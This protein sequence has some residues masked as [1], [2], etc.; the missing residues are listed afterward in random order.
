MAASEDL[1][2][3]D[4]IESQKENIQSL[5]G[6]RSARKLA[7]LYSPQA[8][9]VQGDKLAPILTPTPNPGDTKTLHDTIRADFEAEVAVAAESD[10][11]LDVYDR[12]VRWTLD[13]YPSAQATP[14]SQ[15]HVLLERATKAFVGTAQYRNDP[16]Y[17]RLWLHYIHFFSDA[18]RETYLYLSRHGIGENLALFYEE[19]AGWLEGAT[20][21]AQADEVFRLGIER[22]ARPQ[23]RLMRKY[24]EFEQRRET[25]APESLDPDAPSSPAL[26]TVRPALAAKV[27]PFASAAAASSDPQEAIRQQEQQRQR[28][29]SGQA[30]RSA[31]SK[32]AIFSDAGASAGGPAL[33]AAGTTT[34][35]WESIGSLTERKKENTVAAKPWAGEKLSAGGK[36]PKT[37]M[38]V[39]KDAVQVNPASGKKERVFVD[40]R[41]VYPTPEEPGTELSF[42]EIW[43]ANRGLLHCEWDTPAKVE[44]DLLF[45][46]VPSHKI[47]VL[48][49]DVAS[50]LV[51]HHD[52]VMLDEN[53]AM[54]K[55]NGQE[56]RSRKKKF[57]EANVTQIIKAKLDSPSKPKMK[58]KSSSTSEPTM[59]MHTRA[60]TDDIYEIFNQPK[61]QGIEEEED[62]EP[63][64]DDYET[65]GDYTSGAESTGTA[66]HGSTSDAGDEEEEEEE[67]DGT[68]AD[69]D[70]IDGD[71]AGN[72]SGWSDFAA[73]K[74]VTNLQ[75]DHSTGPNQSTTTTGDT[76]D[77]GNSSDRDEADEVFSPLP[78]RS[79][80]HPAGVDIDGDANESK[81][82]SLPSSPLRPTDEEDEQQQA[83]PRT[84]TVFIP[85]PPEDYVAPTRPYR[86]PAEVANNRLPFMT[87]ITE[88]TESSLEFDSEDNKRALHA[89]TPSKAVGNRSFSLTSTNE[90]DEDEDE[91]EEVED[92][93][94]DVMVDEE[95]EEERTRSG[96]MT[97]PMSSPLIDIVND[98]ELPEPAPLKLSIFKDPVVP[99]TADSAPSSRAPVP[100]KGPIITETQCNPIDESI[101]A[102]ILAKM[103]P[104][105]SSYTGF[106]D[107]REEKCDKGAEIRRYAKAVSGKSKANGNGGSGNGGG[108]SDR[109][110]GAGVPVMIQ[111]ADCPSRYTVRR[112]IGAGAFAP[113]YL[114]ENM[115]PDGENSTGAVDDEQQAVA[116]MGRGAFA[117]T[118]ARRYALEALKMENPPTTWEFHMMRLAHTRLGP[119][120]RA[121]A[122]LAPALE[123][124]LY[125]D[126]TFLFLPYYPHGTLLDVVNLFRSEPSGV[127]DETLAMFFAIELFRTVESLHGKNIL[128]GDIKADNCLL[129]L[130]DPLSTASSLSSSTSSS[131]S[132]N[133]DG[134]EQ[135]SS[136]W[137][138]DGTGGWAARGMTLIDFGRAID[139]RA[140]PAD[141]KFVADWKTTAQDC[142]EMREGRPWTWQIDYHGLAGA[143]HCLLFGKYMETVRCD[144][145]MGAAFGG[146][147]AGAGGIGAALERGPIKRYRIRETLKR[148]WQTDIWSEAFELLLNP[149]G[150][151]SAEDGG[152][153]PALRSMRQ[154]RERME[155]WLAANCERG[156]GLKSLMIKIEHYARTRK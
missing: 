79:F 102:E 92:D 63:S 9:G 30:A 148:Y 149:A 6:G 111:F 96:I 88:R 39:F 48:A 86:D 49:D 142:A 73:Q 41:A 156:V 77:V 2:N 1:I 110:S 89:K 99:P 80:S 103:Q 32:M 64:D 113:V 53:G 20:R 155:T 69:A 97:E 55:N 71:E 147:T 131:N 87:P 40:L 85:I 46:P 14:Q 84:R 25:Q 22:N 43:A 34:K 154:I 17:L 106:Y 136:Q 60:A 36:K 31:K 143:L 126:E 117:S 75:E 128:H 4:V 12:Y 15:L 70:A 65:D 127:M 33:P 19:Y 18:P 140:F 13:A 138:A 82:P 118:H 83:P 62:N 35:G 3:F 28:Q 50:K 150:F 52:V 37:K 57:V 44:Q 66:R 58:K 98:N 11:P 93:D 68:E 151:V 51:V 122:S 107:H 124:H 74:H 153:L 112:E 144:Q 101:R 108:G 94:D 139:M 47:D 135:L 24:N 125:R 130:E 26:P 10:D 81:V 133:A 141:V 23:A 90:D 100:P 5:P 146:D 129:R 104:P 67:A 137:K 123:C 132:R 7:E 105:L 121:T 145:G 120:H 21:W 78:I 116:Q 27:D 29:A 91:D 54:V 45:S 115:N 119:Q 56:N 109:S 134:S 76:D 152:K 95:G 61:K 8:V 59:T 42:E 16:R 114:V 38:A 72:V